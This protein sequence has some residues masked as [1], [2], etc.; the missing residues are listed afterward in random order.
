MKGKA[1]R[2]KMKNAE[3]CSPNRR[4]GSAFS[5]RRPAETKTRV[6]FCLNRKRRF[7]HAFWRGKKYVRHIL[8]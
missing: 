3:D 6:V 5:C 8:K 2:C 7:L 1:R 4:S